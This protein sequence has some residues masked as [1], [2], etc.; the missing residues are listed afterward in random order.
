MDQRP[1]QPPEGE[2]IEGAARRM[3]ISIRA[4]AKRAGMSYGRWRQIVKGYQNVSPGEFAIVRAPAATVAKMAAVVGVT[5]EELGTAGKRADAAE[6]LRQI[7]ATTPPQPA[8]HPVTADF[9]AFAGVT[10]GDA[11]DPY[12]RSVREDLILAILEH[13]PAPTGAQIFH[14]NPWSDTEARLWDD[15]TI[16][17]QDREVAIASTRKVRD[18][19]A[20]DENR[21]TG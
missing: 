20:R 19:Y 15:E 1:P 17:R 2:L 14:G 16:R 10:P 18:E 21:K 4:A 8:Y 11:E 6:E 7:Q 12:I 13:G 3:K 5:P 9:A